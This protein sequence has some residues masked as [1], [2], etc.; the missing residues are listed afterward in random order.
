MH[1]LEEDDYPELYWRGGHD[2]RDEAERGTVAP[3]ALADDASLGVEKV[4]N[5]T[6][7]VP[8]GDSIG[9]VDDK[10]A[11][12]ADVTHK[13]DNANETESSSP[14]LA[15]ESTATSLSTLAR[16]PSL[17][18]IERAATTAKEGHVEFAES[19]RGA[20]YNKL[21][22]PYVAGAT[23][24]TL[25]DPYIRKTYQVRNLAEFLETVYTYTNRSDEVHV[26]LITG[27]D[28]EYPDRQIDNLSQVQA[29]FG[30]LGI[31]LT[32]EFSES[33]HDR[34]IVTDTGWRVILGRGLD[35]YQR[36]SD[37]DWLNPLTRQQKLRRVKEFS[38]TYQRR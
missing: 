13:V 1:V 18:P 33:G 15:T 37:N 36:Y 12:S 38:V 6:S 26:H 5:T 8:A 20:T 2:E 35:I 30:T 27:C 17:S 21:F 34:S 28:E 14:V 32:Y 9:S 7:D 11:A 23:Q 3:V 19:Q 4:D 16:V 31:A 25:K 29:T 22:G 24:I 10:A